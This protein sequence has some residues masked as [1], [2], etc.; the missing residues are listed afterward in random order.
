MPPL[1]TK[2]RSLNR[3]AVSSTA[4]PSIVNILTQTIFSRQSILQISRPGTICPIQKC[5]SFRFLGLHLFIYFSTKMLVTSRPFFHVFPSS[6]PGSYLFPYHS[7]KPLY[8]H[9]CESDEQS[10]RDLLK[11]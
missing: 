4:S 7:M 10:L 6:R 11:A 1:P 2:G 9:L 3:D 8:Q 5:L